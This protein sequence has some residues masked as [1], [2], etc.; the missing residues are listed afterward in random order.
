MMHTFMISK[1]IK[2]LRTEGLDLLV[3]T[4]NSD[5]LNLKK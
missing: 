2:M 4:E 3:S 5:C 1:P